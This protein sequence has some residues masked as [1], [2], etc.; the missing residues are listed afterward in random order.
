[1]I[2]PRIWLLVQLGGLLLP[3]PLSLFPTPCQL[4]QSLSLSFKQI[5]SLRKER[6]GQRGSYEDIHYKIIIM[7]KVI[8][9]FCVLK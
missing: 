8:N 3:L 4:M 2:E 1:M 7:A 5:K 9:N 6:S